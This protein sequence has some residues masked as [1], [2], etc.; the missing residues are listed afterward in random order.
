MYTCK[1]CNT[2]FKSRMSIMNHIIRTHKCTGQQY[3]DKFYKKKDEGL[4]ENCKKETKFLNIDDGYAK[5]CC[6]KCAMPGRAKRNIEKYGYADNFHNP[7]IIKLSHSEQAD[8]KRKATMKERYGV[9]SY[10]STKEFQQISKQYF[11]EHKK[12]ITAKS[13]QT[14]IDKYGVSCNFKRQDIIEKN[15]V[16][17]HTPE[18]NEKRK[19][20]TLK[21]FGVENVFQLPEVK[22]KAQRNSHTPEVMAKMHA[23]RDYRQIAIKSA[24]TKKKNGNR[25]TLELKFIYL[26]KEH[27]IKYIEE[28]SDDRY[29]FP[30][31]FYLPDLDYFVELHGSWV[32]GGHIFNK[33]KDKQKLEKWQEKVKTSNYYKVALKTWTIKD[34]NKL[35]TAKK[36]NL[37]YILLWSLEDIDKWFEL[38]CPK[39]KSY[40]TKGWL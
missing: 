27:N 25:S 23:N 8:K 26:C 30:C 7:N 32:H 28:Y 39:N 33:R 38:N 10:T 11:Q 19:Q 22:E 6:I 29:P 1:F 18:V 16:A 3:Y 12:E 14:N 20:T 2:E 34:P 17:S 37:N 15:K 5:C 21:H 13:K 36:N 35:K 24:E 4:C 31:D 9:E 40:T